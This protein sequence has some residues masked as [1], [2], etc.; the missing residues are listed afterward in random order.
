MFKLCVYAACV[1][2]FPF[3]HNDTISVRFRCEVEWFPSRSYLCAPNPP[4][5]MQAYTHTQTNSYLWAFLIVTCLY[6]KVE[7]TFSLLSTWSNETPHLKVDMS[8]LLSI[9]KASS[10]ALIGFHCAIFSPFS[11][12][13]RAIST[14]Q[15][16]SN[17]SQSMM[18]VI[19][20]SQ[21][22]K[23]YINS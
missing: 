7:T 10:L 18:C 4:I 12:H 22:A 20:A 11:T 16:A 17:P 3:A 19:G 9:L 5:H 23:C 6:S 8:L 1:C 13:V 14:P 15:S 2:L 21:T